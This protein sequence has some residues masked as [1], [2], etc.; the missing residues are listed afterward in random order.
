L[1]PFFLFRAVYEKNKE[2]FWQTAILSFCAL[3][4]IALIFSFRSSGSFEQRFHFIGLSTFG[5]TMWTQGIALFAFGYAQAHEWGRTLFVLATQNIA[6]FQMWGRLLLATGVVLLFLLS[7]NL[8]R[9]KRLLFLGSYLI[10]MLL[11]MMFSVI[12]DKYALIDTGF[13]QRMFLA[14]NIVLGWMLLA[15]VR[16]Q[17]GKGWRAVFSN[18]VSA[19]CAAIIGASLFWGIQTYRERWFW[20]EYWPD[21]KAEV[22]AWRA[23]PG[24]PL[25]IQPEGW[26][27]QLKK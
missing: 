5:V 2:R 16:F 13:H 15:G 23:N 24:V 4:Q 11:P 21:W 10:L 1:I 19:F 27:V 14:P 17:K 7:S 12:Q 25:Q 22:S 18:L 9:I 6:S 3:I 20:I 8:S 26:T